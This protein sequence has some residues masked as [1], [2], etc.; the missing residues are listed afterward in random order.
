[1]TN[2]NIV[3][4]EPLANL[5]NYW[6]YAHSVESRSGFTINPSR[7]ININ[8]I[9]DHIQSIYNIL[10][11]GINTDY[12]HNV[13]YKLDWGG[14]VWCELS[15]IDYWFNL[16]MWSMLLKT[17]QIIKP[18]HIFWDFELKKIFIKSFIDKFILNIENKIK[19]GE[20]LNS[21]CADGT[22]YYS[23]I[24]AFAF[25]L[26]NTI[27]N[28]DDIALMKA[29]PEFRQL[30]HTSFEDVPFAEVKDYG[31]QITNK[32]I[33]IIKMSKQFLGY[34]HGLTNSFKSQEA[35]NP[36]QYKESR[37][38]IGTKSMHDSVYPVVINAS[39]SNGGVNV[40]VY[41]FTESSTARHAQIVSKE[42]VGES[43]DFA[44]VL[45]LNNTDVILNINSKY[46]C[47]TKNYIKFE[48][49]SKEHLK[50]IK[51]RY[52][53]FN[54]NGMDHIIDENDDSLI[55]KK[56][57]LYS[58]ITCSSMSHGMGICKRCYGDL[59]YT[60]RKI[61]VGKNAAELLSSKLTQRLLSAK[62]LL[63][64]KIVEIKWNAEFFDLFAVDIN[65]IQLIQD[66]EDEIPNLRKYTMII[67]PNNISLVN[68]EEDTV[69][70]DDDSDNI[71]YN[72]YITK[73]IIRY[74][75]GR[76]IEFKSEDD[77]PLYLT[78]ELNNIIRRKA[79]NDDECVNITL[80]KLT[81]ATLFR[82]KIN[83]D[84]ISKTMND[85]IKCINKSDITENLSKSEITQ[86]MLDLVIYGDLDID[87]IH[88]EII[89]ANQCVA[90]DDIL[91]KVN[92]D[93]PNA[94]YKMITLNK[95]LT[96]NPSVIV[97]LLY[98]DLGRTLY[99]PLTFRKN[100]P[101]FF[102]LFFAEKPQ[103]Y[104]SDDIIVDRDDVDILEHDTLIEMCKIVDK[105][106]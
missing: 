39:F 18:K 16:F 61:N 85:I 12:V 99:N 66:I 36:R 72:E 77:D 26:S 14:D 105:D 20:S 64:T 48:I 102:D 60:N 98:K 22:W 95:A 32:G 50:R 41:Y 53:R 57:Y 35:I 65:S 2:F 10:K 3:D 25:Y 87:S 83:N 7:D 101:S 89:L 68:D 38:N 69:K 62:H 78:T 103:V 86:R 79:T 97:S 47:G 49:K 54:K 17:E 96:N 70:S 73:F 43:G 51:N 80:D 74:P 52:Y 34:E 71:L 31:Q 46:S 29:C 67:D 13:K 40:P 4:D 92:W 1:M 23:Y 28:E 27:N 91:S 106:K 8:N 81:D 5:K 24:E 21:V 63:E 76:E 88:L 44:R 84:E 56:I 104:M 100:A 58:P 55:G 30:M 82:I 93:V 75:D 33:D 59:Y 45:G 37:F 15:I 42:N 94:D 11:D 90:K 9:D 19:Y 6:I